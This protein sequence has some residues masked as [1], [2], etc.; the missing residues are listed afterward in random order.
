M[1]SRPGLVFYLDCKYV[2]QS[3]T[4][5]ECGVLLRAIL[6]YA[7]TGSAPQFDDRILQMAWGA[8][9]PR[10][11]EDKRRYEATVQQRRDAAN[12]RWGKDTST[13]SVDG[14]DKYIDW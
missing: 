9:H 8:I 13:P 14:M 3:L 6:D 7:D 11:D 10:L 4:D 2:F 5:A 12:K 1:M